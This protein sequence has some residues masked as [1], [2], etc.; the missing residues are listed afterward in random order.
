[1]YQVLDAL[2]WAPPEDKAVAGVFKPGLDRG[3][4]LS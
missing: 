2:R 4:A 3:I 1:M